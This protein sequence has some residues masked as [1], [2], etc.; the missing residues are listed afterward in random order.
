[1]KPRSSLSIFMNLV[2]ALAPAMLA[3][4]R[5]INGQTVWIE[6]ESS[7]HASVQ[8]HPSWYDKVKKDMLSGGGWISHW[9]ETR[10]GLVDYSVQVPAEGRYAFWV[11]A[12]PMQSRLSYQIGKGKWTDIDLT[13][14]VLDSVNVAADGKPDIRFLGWKK[15]G[16]L[17]LV[18]GT[19][20][21]RFKLSSP[22]HHHGAIDAFVLTTKPFVPEGS[23]RPG[24][25]VVRTNAPAGTWSFLPERDTFSPQAAFDLRQL[26]E[27]TAGESGFVRLSEDGESF[28][29]GNGQPARF[30]AICTSLVRGHSTQDLAHH[31]RFLAKRGVNMIRFHGEVESKAKGAGLT[32]V[33][34]KEIDDAWRLVAAMKKEGIYTTISPYWA[35]SLKVVP[36]SWGIEGWPEKQNPQGL[37]FFNPR[38]QEGYK[39]WLKAL[40]SPVN[41]HTG[42]PLAEDPALAIIQLQNEDSMLFWTM[43]GV[44]GRQLEVLGEQFGHWLAAKYGS[45]ERA[46][47]AW[48]GDSMRQDDVSRGILGIHIA[49]EWTQERSGGRKRRLD[50]Q[51]QFFTETM[52][53]FNREIARYLREDLGC[54]QLI[55][56]GNWKTADT[57]RLN[58]AERWSYTANEVL[59]VNRYYSPVHVGQDRGWRIN[60]GDTFEDASVLVNPRALPLNLKQVAGHP[61]IITESHWVPPLGFQ[62]EGPFLV[63][64]MQSLTGVDAFYWLGTSKAE[65]SNA[66]RADWDAAS[67]NKWEVATPMILGQFPAAA[68]LYREGYLKQGDPVVV[69]HRSLQQLWERTP[70]LISE[71]PSYDP[72]RDQGDSARRS[73]VRTKVDPLA[74][75]TGPVKVVYDADPNKSTV[76]DL[77]KL[78]D[79][80][81]KTVRSVTGEISWDYGEGICSIDAPRA[82]GASG[83]LKKR[84]RIQLADVAIESTNYYGTVLVVSLDGRPL[85]QSEKVLV[86]V[87][88]VARPTGWL[89]RS[90]DFQAGQGKPLHH[91]KRVIDT[92]K[93]PWVVV[94]T[95]VKL[96]VSNPGLKKATRLDL[97]GVPAGSVAASADGGAFSLSLPKDSLYVLLEAR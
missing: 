32:D 59:A 84:P 96:S 28:V 95:A 52:Y 2:F 85:K 16:D 51:L 12:N 5:A 29:L 30:W 82:Q 58:D 71:D 81:T 36:G 90:E 79:P 57:T 76:T 88:T 35:A 45:V 54:K 68:L 46:V 21:F 25:T 70:P 97:N 55:N 44:K 43:Q 13:T 91:G 67:R 20:T 47:Q 61:M 69:E 33:N 10:D 94:D 22:N 53:N 86:Q 40:L 19:Y 41:P 23:R 50:D 34:T 8:R 4:P 64:A 15:V 42:I 37:L 89:E 24:T 80:A 18:K 66:D 56:A 49:W 14:D 83:F 27:K 38:L 78:I 72:N 87:G 1:M 26:N 65:W 74:F 93:M 6:G 60:K 63:A 73:T 31:A 48:N 77:Q 39:A 9:S 11:R 3:F 62:S 92:G 75:L 7:R 17:P